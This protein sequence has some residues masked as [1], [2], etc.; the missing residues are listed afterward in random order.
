MSLN[1]ETLAELKKLG[2]LRDAG[3]INQEEFDAEKVR[4]MKSSAEVE[5]TTAAVSTEPVDTAPAKSDVVGIPSSSG[6]SG[7]LMMRFKQNLDHG[8]ADIDSANLFNKL[9][10][11]QAAFGFRIAEKAM[12]RIEEKGLKNFLLRCLLAYI[13]F[14]LAAGLIAGVMGFIFG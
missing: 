8:L 13:A 4:L 10:L 2:E 1:P 3:I 12:K 7:S 11:R 6:S 14:C 9:R 5:V